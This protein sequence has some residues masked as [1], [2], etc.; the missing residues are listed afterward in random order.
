MEGRFQIYMKD[1]EFRLNALQIEKDKSDDKLNA[2]VRQREEVAKENAHLRT[3]VLDSE[4][5][6]TELDKEQEKNREIYR[7]FHKVEVELNT[8]TSMEQELTEINMRLKSE[9]SFHLAEVQRSK[10]HISRVSFYL[11]HWKTCIFTPLFSSSYYKY[12]CSCDIHKYDY[13]FR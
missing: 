9:I 6:R 8:N 12:I 4:N 5:L 13:I 3:L 1:A 2:F 10:E 11:T 7:K